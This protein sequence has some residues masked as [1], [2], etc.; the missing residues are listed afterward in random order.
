[1]DN[2][3]KQELD[4][5]G[6]YELRTVARNIGVKSPTTKK[7]DELVECILKIQNG[8]EKASSSNKGRPPKKISLA[9][10]NLDLDKIEGEPRNFEYAPDSNDGF[11]LSSCFS[12]PFKELY[13]C[14]GVLRVVEDKKYIYNHMGVVRFVM[15][16]DEMCQKYGLKFGDYV[17]GKAYNISSRIGKLNSVQEINFANITTSCGTD[18]KKIVI[19]GSKNVKEIYDNILASEKPIRVAIELEVNDY[20]VITL[21]DDCIYFY[22]HELDDIKRSYNALLDC[23]QVV[24]ELS[25]NNK[26]FSLYLLD[27]DYIFIVLSV[28]LASKY[29]AFGN[30]SDAGQFIKTLLAYV[31]NSTCGNAVIY[32]SKN[33]KRNEYLDAILNKY[34]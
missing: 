23:M 8:E 5:L 14:Q 21:R 4:A 7:H 15:V 34:L 17:V 19:K 26:P 30:Y 6:I 24:K 12:G 10:S 9:S 20:G 13:S 11:C 2:Y 3:K 33:Y 1:M 18:D 32:E 31:K 25:E 27:I 22:S 28:H 16:D 29:D